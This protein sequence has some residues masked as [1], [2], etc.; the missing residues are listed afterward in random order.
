MPASEN[1]GS[2]FVLAPEET[3]DPAGQQALLALAKATALACQVPCCA[4]VSETA[5][6]SHAE[7]VSGQLP[8]EER[9]LIRDIRVFTQTKP[10]VELVRPDFITRNRLIDSHPLRAKSFL[11]AHV[12]RSEQGSAVGV[13]A[14]FGPEQD[15]DLEALGDKL[16]SMTQATQTVL[17]AEWYYDAY[18]HSPALLYSTDDRGIIEEVSQLWLTHFG[19]KRSEVIGRSPTD[20]M[21]TS[22]R[23]DLEGF[24]NHIHLTAGVKDFPSQFV[25]AG[26]RVVEVLMSIAL[27]RQANGQV[28]KASQRSKCLLV[29]ITLQIQIQR[30][31][32]ARAR[33]DEMTGIPNRA[34]IRERFQVEAARSARHKRPLSLVMFDADHFK[35]LNDQHGHAAGDQALVIL[36]NTARHQLRGADEVGRIG[37]EEF[38]LVLPETGLAGAMHVA[39]RLRQGVADI[40]VTEVG[41]P[42]PLTISLGVI[43]V[44]P[45]TSTDQAF[46][47]ADAAMYEAKRTG[48]NR[49]VSWRPDLPSHASAKLNSKP[50]TEAEAMGPIV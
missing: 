42:C 45:G 16:E 5:Q 3:P 50:V 32:E 9:A 41:L 48:R 2:G 22:A 35:R 8:D 27:E 26:G 30:A 1:A 6:G 4:L 31:L 40:P 34:W 49:V 28:D 47:R 7:A 14:L 33:L 24:S 23:Q 25:T 29:D 19:Y 36:A 12:L 21:T 10:I 38:A 15:Q 17:R 37:G 39:E 43:E 20:F 11:A 46:A 18:I 44:G 13:L